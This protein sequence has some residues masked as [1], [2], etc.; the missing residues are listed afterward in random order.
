M[1]IFMHLSRSRLHAL[2]SRWSRFGRS[3]EMTWNH[4]YFLSS[5]KEKETENERRWRNR[6]QKVEGRNAL[7]R[8][9]KKQKEFQEEEE[10]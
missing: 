3:Y 6:R 7:R 8:E 5:L 9:R 1:D 10:E 2:I 4:S